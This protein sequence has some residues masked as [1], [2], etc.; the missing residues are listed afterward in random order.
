MFFF[1]KFCLTLYQTDIYYLQSADEN[2]T[3]QE[4]ICTTKFTTAFTLAP[5]AVSITL[6]AG[7]AAAWLLLTEM[8]CIS[9]NK[10]T[11]SVTQVTE[12]FL[13]KNFEDKI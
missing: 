3:L 9:G 6:E 12:L 11:G 8:F 5:A 4:E 13:L 2:S 10:V 7:P 1:S